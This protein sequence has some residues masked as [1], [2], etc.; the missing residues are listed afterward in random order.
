MYTIVTN[1]GLWLWVFDTTFNYIYA[2]SWRSILL[3]EETEYPEKTTDLSKV[4]DS[5]IHMNLYRV[6]LVMSG[7][8]THNV[9]GD[10]HWLHG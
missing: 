10:R 8:R 9:S 4:I 6:H 2:I 5:L 7:T 3:A 1:R